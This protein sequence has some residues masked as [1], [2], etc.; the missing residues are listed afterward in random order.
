MILR[1]WDVTFNVTDLD[2]ATDFIA[3]FT[4]PDGNT[5]QMAQVDWPEYF[6]ACA[7]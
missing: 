6:A 2:K 4:D 7:T 1:V 3:L 5:L